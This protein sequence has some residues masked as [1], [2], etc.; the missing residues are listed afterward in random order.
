MTAGM[1][2]PKALTAQPD[3]I[4]EVVYRAFR[5]KLDIVYANWKWSMIMMLIRLLPESVFKKRQI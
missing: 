4:A 3:E 5:R 1:D 2:L